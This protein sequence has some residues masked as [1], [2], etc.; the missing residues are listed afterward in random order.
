MLNMECAL[1]DSVM[2]E[3]KRDLE[4]KRNGY[5][6]KLS[7]ITA[8]V[9]GKCGNIEYMAKDMKMAE[10]LCKVM[11]DANLDLKGEYLDVSDMAEELK[12]SNQTIYNMIKDKR[13]KPVKIGNRWR[14]YK[15]D[16]DIMKNNCAYDNFQLAA[17]NL[18]EKLV[19]ADLEILKKEMEED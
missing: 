11:S 15:K 9:C 8:Y 12:V 1:C 6:L 4:I 10:N 17:R 14:F 18:H 7:G 5:E 19:E 3:E 2:T 16:I 13:L